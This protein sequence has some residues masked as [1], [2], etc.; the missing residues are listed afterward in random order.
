MKSRRAGFAGSALVAGLATLALAGCASGSRQPLSLTERDS[1]SACRQQANDIYDRQNRGEIYSVDPNWAPSSSYGLGS[2]PT[3][4]LSDQ[5]AHERLV[6]NCVRN[7]GAGSNAPVASGPSNA[8]VR[9]PVRPS[10]P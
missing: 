4:G 8:P 7:T 2:L 3:N 5:Y 9:Y 6:D 10:S 1:I